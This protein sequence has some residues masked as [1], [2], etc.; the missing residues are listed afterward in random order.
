M[1]RFFPI[2]IL[3]LWLLAVAVA[4][5]STITPNQI[6]LAGILKAPGIDHWFGQD[7]LGRSVLYRLLAGAQ[8]SLT[9]SVSVT[10]LCALIG[11]FIGAVAAWFGGLIEHVVVRVI[12]L[13]MA[14]PG[15]LLAIALAGI[16][17]PGINNLVIALSV[18]GWVGFARLTRAQMLALKQREHVQAA[19]ALGTAT[20]V[21]IFRHLLPLIAAPLI[22]EATFTV[23]SVIIAEAGLSF[24]GI[25]IQPPEAS[26]GNMIKDGARYLLIAPHLVIAPGMALALVVLAINMLGDQLRD[27]LDKKSHYLT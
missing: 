19:Q 18:V 5:Y 2:A 24:L 20:P 16:L 6:D 3:L 10:L 21:I 23:A 8:T 27:H 1:K 7:D 15:I 13:F 17:G 4:L 25:G 12:D 9:V 26:W 22:I 11:I 14:F